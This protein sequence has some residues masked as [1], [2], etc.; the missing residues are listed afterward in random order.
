MADPKNNEGSKLL[1]GFTP[2]HVQ[3]YDINHRPVDVSSTE[4]PNLFQKGH[5]TFNTKDSI[6]MIDSSGK[7]VYIEPQNFNRALNDGWKFDTPEMQAK[8][9]VEEKYSETPEQLKAGLEAV[10]R[11]L[12]F[13][14]SDPVLVSLGADKDQL[15]AREEVNPG[16]AATGEIVGTV[17]PMLLS[18]GAA[19]GAPAVRGLAKATPVMLTTKAGQLF[20]RSVQGLVGQEAKTFAGKAI[21]KAIPKMAG[22]AVEGAIYGAAHT[23]SEAALGD[24]ELNAETLMANVGPAALLGG[25]IGGGVGFLEATAPYLEKT[26]MTAREKVGVGA[27]K[28]MAAYYGVSPETIDDFIK[29]KPSV[30]A[31]SPLADIK[32][33][34]HFK[35]SEIHDSYKKGEMKYDQAV[36]EFK[37][38]AKSEKKAR[39]LG[40]EKEEELLR[41]A[42]DEFD[43]YELSYEE[44][45]RN[46]LKTV[47]EKLVDNSQRLRE[48]MIAK[49]NASFDLVSD[50][51]FKTSE[52]QDAW[53]KLA[54]E[55]GEGVTTAK[56]SV[57][58]WIKETSD[59]LSQYGDNL[60]GAQVKK[61]I[62]ELDQTLSGKFNAGA[63]DFD[64]LLTNA[65][66]NIRYSLDDILKSASPEY[67]MAMQDVSGDVKLLKSLNK[68]DDYREALASLEN[69]S[70]RLT[71]Q[72]DLLQIKKLEE[73]FGESYSKD[74]EE[75]VNRKS[76]IEG[77]KAA[78][79]LSEKK[80]LIDR[81]KSKEA[82]E[83]FEQQLNSSPEFK[84]MLAK[85]AELNEQILTKENLH[86]VTP[87]Q[88]RGIVDKA[89]RGDKIAI[90][91]VSAIEKVTGI[92][93]LAEK[94]K[95]SGVKDAFD[96]TFQRGSRNVLLNTVMG[97]AIGGVGGGV[98]GAAWGMIVDQF[99]P[100]IAKILLNKYISLAAMEKMG[101]DVSKQMSQKAANFLNQ[102]TLLEAGRKYSL[103]LMIDFKSKEEDKEKKKPRSVS[104]LTPE[105]WGKVSEQ[106]TKVASNP[107]AVMD[108]A[109]DSL[110]EIS[111]VAPNIGSSM[112]QKSVVA[113]QF[114]YSKLPKDPL[115]QFGMMKSKSWRP[116]DYELS[117]FSRYLTAVNDPVS[118]FSDLEAGVIT[119][120][121]V[122]ALKT[123]YPKMYNSVV[124]QMAENMA[125]MKEDLPYEKKLKLSIFFDVPMDAAADPQ[126]M[127][128][129][130]QAHTP[131]AQQ[132][133]D[134]ASGQKINTTG[135]KN[136]NSS[137]LESGTES[138]LNRA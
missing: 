16:I 21:Q 32:D 112:I 1:E 98:A 23:V 40:I 51:N 119:N 14:L 53:G 70:G 109:S 67:K 33:D 89:S 115:A 9:F 85:Q 29:Y 41:S 13:G 91:Q 64:K 55:Y 47:A 81:L 59:W 113:T 77:S 56:K 25:A 17:A 133:A 63:A 68:Y 111:K 72:E 107:S 11:G 75:F 78:Q 101:I 88:V 79:R 2:D 54:K 45:S 38:F 80:S 84:E 130:Q 128:A 31:A 132:N 74:I 24:A 104:R 94:I 8:R 22:S 3:A 127:M 102:P 60:N 103:P 42:K 120:E 34:L 5:L 126:F 114:L 92:Q 90:R 93:N 7:K 19:A 15:K 65:Q 12:S 97:S 58:A 35:L 20:E 86:G 6:P 108:Q 129:M 105:E 30:D 18:G 36:K 46:K 118:V 62:Q 66:K 28:M 138:I 50:L 125:E 134:Q 100:S 27:K 76:N 52:I 4:L 131:Q 49:S 48:S 87:G 37:D 83:I 106:I 73:Q 137:K 116:S 136:I 123:V 117:K 135:L 26:F 57:G 44:S 110:K 43:N 61:I 95:I 82:S 71:K 10:A 121:Q 39:G 96:K 69:M 99:G 124:Q 122:E